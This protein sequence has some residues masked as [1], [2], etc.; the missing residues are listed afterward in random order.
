MRDQDM[1]QLHAAYPSQDVFRMIA[2]ID[3]YP[4]L[5]LRSDQQVTIQLKLASGNM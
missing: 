4:L 1:S 5:A 3:Q 2:R